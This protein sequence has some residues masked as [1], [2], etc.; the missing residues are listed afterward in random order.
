[1]PKKVE[2]VEKQSFLAGWL[3]DHRPLNVTEITSLYF[4]LKKSIMTKA[5]A[6]GFS[7]TAQSKEVRSFM[8][9][10]VELA[11][12]HINTFRSKLHEDFVSSS[13][14]WD[15]H[16]TDSQTAPFSD[17]LM[18]AHGGFLLQAAIAYYGTAFSSS[19]RR[20]LGA[21]YSAAVARIAQVAEDG[22]NIMIANN[23][24][25]KPPH[26]VDRNEIQKS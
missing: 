15:T 11:E 3:G 10:V 4:N 26:T 2:F 25:E 20:D 9:G 5:L 18:M 16:I 24:F 17:K 12:N 22:M 1:M 21:E 8:K 6:L 13:I 19:T 23:W 14:F 7:Q